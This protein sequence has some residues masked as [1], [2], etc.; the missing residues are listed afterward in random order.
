MTPRESTLLRETLLRA[1]RMGARLFRNQVGAGVAGTVLREVEPGLF[2]VRGHRVTMGLCPGSADL[3]GWRTVEITPAMVGLRLAL[4]AAIEVKSAAGKAT[5][6][7]RNFLT[8]VREAGGLAAII[9]DA[10]DC[11]AALFGDRT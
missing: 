11:D 6:E 10:G 4:F 1:S 9:R 8:R 5:P 2:L 7:Q 3:V